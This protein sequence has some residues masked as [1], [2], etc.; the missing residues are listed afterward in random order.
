MMWA[1]NA[2][3]L[4]VMVPEL[5]LLL[6]LLGLVA[7]STRGDPESPLRWTTK[8]MRHLAGALAGQGHR[9][10]PQTAWRLLREQGYS[11]Q[12]PA[13]VLEGARHPDRDAQ[14]RYIAAR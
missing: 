11:V 10:S 12:A 7:D 5:R 13:K 4:N 3:L 8:S 14:F 6:A 9:C 2:E 1:V